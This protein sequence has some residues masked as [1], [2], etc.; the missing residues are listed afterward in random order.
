MIDIEKLIN[1]TKKKECA[2]G[3]CDDVML[4]KSQ[5]EKEE[6]EGPPSIP[7]LSAQIQAVAMLRQAPYTTD[8]APPRMLQDLTVLYA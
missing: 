1:V 2:Q 7:T 8:D 6:H 3:N 4:M 5:D